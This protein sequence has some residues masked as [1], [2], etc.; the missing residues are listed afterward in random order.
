MAV[1]LGVAAAEGLAELATLAAGTEAGAAVIGAGESVLADIGI[2]ASEGASEGGLSSLFGEGN[3]TK[4]ATN[5]GKAFIGQTVQK[6][7]NKLQH[8]IVNQSTRFVDS[9]ADRAVNIVHPNPDNRPVHH[10]N[11]RHFTDLPTHQGDRELFHT[12][13]IGR[14][15]QHPFERRSD[16]HRKRK[17]ENQQIAVVGSDNPLSTPAPPAHLPQEWCDRSYD[18]ATHP[19]SKRVADHPDIVRPVYVTQN[20]QYLDPPTVHVPNPNQHIIQPHLSNITD[21]NFYE[22]DYANYNRDTLNNLLSAFPISI[23]TAIAGGDLLDIPNPV[24]QPNTYLPEQLNPPHF[25]YNASMLLG[26][27]EFTYY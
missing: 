12:P 21:F 2:G 15:V 16:R 19:P 7:S 8:S 23:G 26:D 1:V 18:V 24:Q 14:V 10:P 5:L 6:A 4:A 27:D 25:G 11:K 17:Y 13:S 20:V 3:L 9:I 22:H